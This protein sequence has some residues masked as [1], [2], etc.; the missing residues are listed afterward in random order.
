[1]SK[2][3]KRATGVSVLAL[4]WVALATPVLDQTAAQTVTDELAND[5]DTIVVTAQKRAENLQDVPIAITALNAAALDAAKIED[6]GA[7]IVRATEPSEALL[8]DLA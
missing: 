8:F 3:H 5:R 7:I 6:E 4:S 2:T 1:M